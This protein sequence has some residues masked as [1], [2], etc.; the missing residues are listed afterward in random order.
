MPGRCIVAR[1][2]WLCKAGWSISK[3]VHVFPK[4]TKARLTSSID[5][6]IVNAVLA[7]PL[8]TAL[9]LEGDLGSSALALPVALRTL[10]LVR[11]SGTLDQL[12]QSLSSLRVS[13]WRGASGIAA[14][15]RAFK[16]APAGL[17]LLDIKRRSHLLWRGPD[18]LAGVQCPPG[19]MTLRLQGVGWRMRLPAQLHTLSLNLC[20]IN[21]KLQLP[22]SVRHLWLY[23]CRVPGLLLNEGLQRLHL[24]ETKMD[25]IRVQLPSTLAHIVM[26]PSSNALLAQPLPVSLKILK[27]SESFNA[28]LGLL[29]DSLEELHIGLRFSRPLGPLPLELRSLLISNPDFDHPL[30]DLPA[31]L[32]ELKLPGCFNQQLGPVPQ[33]MEKLMMGRAYSHP[34]QLPLPPSLRELRIGGSFD[35]SLGVL[36]QSLTVLVMGEA[37]SYPLSLPLPSSLRTLHTS[38]SFN[39]SLGVLP[40]ALTELVVQGPF[41]HDLGPLP[42]SLTVLDLRHAPEF[43]YPLPLQA[44]LPASLLRLELRR[45]WGSKHWP[46]PLRLN[47]YGNASESSL[48]EWHHQQLQHHY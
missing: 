48:S 43:D 33:S 11:Y 40:Q 47:W 41:N 35:H 32:L 29:P 15:V 7:R 42:Q 30:G 9:Q 2:G 12:P 37:Y 22:E 8:V 1:E 26:N 24:H 10:E 14:I 36:P 28:P 13:G 18:A 23:S 39:H 17:Q 38:S 4:P 45:D 5:E 46:D 44:E 16:T 34:L 31:Q 19:V 21:T 6:N 3:A 27:L 25:S 20:V